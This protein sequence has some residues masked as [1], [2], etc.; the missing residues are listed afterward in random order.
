MKTFGYYLKELLTIIVLVLFLTWLCG[1]SNDKQ[2]VIDLIHAYGD[3]IGINKTRIAVLKFPIDSMRDEYERQ[4]PPQRYFPGQEKQKQEYINAEHVAYR[5]LMKDIE[6]Y[7]L[8]A[9]V[10]RMI[11]E[12]KIVKYESAIDS[13]KIELYK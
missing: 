9:M 3:S 8:I 7:E 4:F 10:K 13:L 2:H 5:K 11:L 12:Y 6:E 1:C